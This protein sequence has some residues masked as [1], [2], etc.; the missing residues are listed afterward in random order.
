MD[1]VQVSPQ[2][3]PQELVSGR[4]LQVKK[5]VAYG[6]HTIYPQIAANGH[7]DGQQHKVEKKSVRQEPPGF[8]LRYHEHVQEAIDDVGQ[9]GHQEYQAIVQ[10]SLEG[11]LLRYPNRP[12]RVA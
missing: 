4:T 11:E 2:K 3:R 8:G 12:C 5:E 10:R 7:Q 6:E 9:D 1:V